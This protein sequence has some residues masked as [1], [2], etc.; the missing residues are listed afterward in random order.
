MA[1]AGLFI[2]WGA[3]VRGREKK[4]IEVLG[5]DQGVWARAQED[6]RIESFETVLLDPHGG[7]LTGF[8]LVRGTREQLDEIRNDDELR[9]RIARGDLLVERLGVVR[10]TLGDGLPQL[11]NE[12]QELLDEMT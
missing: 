11:M 2:G 3:V 10:A 1:E 8:I 9:R 6:G 7:D 4:A 12:Y 5:D